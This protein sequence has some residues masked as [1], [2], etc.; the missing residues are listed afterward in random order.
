MNENL[1]QMTNS[2][3]KAYIKANR[4]DDQACHEAIK[5]LINRRNA[6]SPQYPYDLHAL[7]LV[8][9]DCEALAWCI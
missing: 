9:E 5:R 8:G 7:R 6:N 4:N 1:A 3:L 2:E